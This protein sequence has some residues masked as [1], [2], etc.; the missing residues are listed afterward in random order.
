MDTKY[1]DVSIKSVIALIK[2][3]LNVL[4]LIEC[5]ASQNIQYFTTW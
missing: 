2:I 4:Q 3:F 5:F 1:F